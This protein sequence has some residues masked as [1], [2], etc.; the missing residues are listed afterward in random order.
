MYLGSFQNECLD[1][2]A[3]SVK[4]DDSNFQIC[5]LFR[6]WLQPSAASCRLKCDLHVLLCTSCV[7]CFTIPNV[8]LP[9]WPFHVAGESRTES[10]SDFPL[11]VSY[12]YRPP[13]LPAPRRD[14]SS[15]WGNFFTGR[16]IVS[17]LLYPGL[18]ACL[19]K[20][21]SLCS[22]PSLLDTGRA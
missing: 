12:R 14:F 2:N 20:Q 11:W 4:S 8:I 16:H 10:H 13:S 22:V 18:Q 15:L 19:S 5:L 9:S 17:F 6:Q 3:S 7:S 1:G 21:P